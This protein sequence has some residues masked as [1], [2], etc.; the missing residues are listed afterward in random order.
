[1]A[2]Y[3]QCMRGWTVE[4]GRGEEVTSVP[5]SLQ[6]LQ[7]G[8]SEYKAVLPAIYSVRPCISVGLL[9]TCCIILIVDRMNVRS[10]SV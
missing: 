8:I 5:I 9:D 6:P 1:M 4:F 3:Q 7:S 10:F 2:T